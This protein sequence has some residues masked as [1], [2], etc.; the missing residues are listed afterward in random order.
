[1]NSGIIKRDFY[2]RSDYDPKSEYAKFIQHL[3]SYLKM[4]TGQIDD[5][6]DSLSGLAE[7]LNKPKIGFA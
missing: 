4:G 2:F 5:A 3:T 1:M 6:P 7:Q